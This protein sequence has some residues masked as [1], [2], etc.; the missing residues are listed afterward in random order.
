MDSLRKKR[1]GVLPFFLFFKVT[2]QL[3]IF[4]YQKHLS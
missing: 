3:K 4:S 2:V 1:E